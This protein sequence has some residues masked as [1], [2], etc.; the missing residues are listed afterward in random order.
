MMDLPDVQ[1]QTEGF[2]HI[3]L[4][5]VGVEHIRAELPVRCGGRV[6]TVPAVFDSYCSLRSEVKGINM[7]RIGRTIRDVINRH[8]KEGL[9]GLGEIVKD[10][11]EAHGNNTEMVRL[12][13]D[14]DLA[15]NRK[16]PVSGTE[17]IQFIPVRFMAVRNCEGELR[18]YVAV[19]AKET[20]L[21]PCSKEMS[22]LSNN[23]TEEER[24]ELEALSPALREKVMMAGFGAHNQISEVTITVEVNAA[25]DRKNGV[26]TCADMAM[27]LTELVRSSVSAP[28]FPVLRRPDEKW[29]TETAYLGGVF[30]AN[31]F[32]E[33]GGGPAFV[34]DIARRATERLEGML[35]TEIRDYMVRVRNQ[36]SI[37][38]DGILA[39]AVTTAHR[40]LKPEFI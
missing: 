21:C 25:S 3:T 39:S 32:E 40:D 22:L 31:G 4:E 10:L 23:V 26:T 34:E 33:T 29:V 28:T 16:A 2:P 12:L 30:T 38:T 37:H 14:F 18:E 13:A 20:S 27:R 6:Q 36:E 8:K 24:R 5:N 15:V 9:E 17:M 19:T 35:D 11:V 1:K 7:S